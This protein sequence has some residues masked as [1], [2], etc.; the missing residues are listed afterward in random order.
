M[1]V[2]FTGYI[3]KAWSRC[4][5]SS[6]FPLLPASGPPQLPEETGSPTLPLISFLSLGTE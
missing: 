3:G 6:Y 4:V 1:A 5:F 2:D